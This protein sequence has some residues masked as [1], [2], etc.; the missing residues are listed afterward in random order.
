MKNIRIRDISDGRILNLRG[1]IEITKSYPREYRDKSWSAPKISFSWEKNSTYIEFEKVEQME[2]F[3][4][5]IVYL[6]KP[7]DID[8]S[9]EPLKL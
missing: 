8:S 1:C 7:I 9:Q 5:N 4:E 2:N 3:Y 6:L